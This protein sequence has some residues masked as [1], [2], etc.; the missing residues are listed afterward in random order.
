MERGYQINIERGFD[1]I[2]ESSP[3]A[4]LL[5]HLNALD[6]Q[7]ETL[8]SAQKADTIKIVP[9][10][11]KSAKTIT[12]P[13]IDVLG[14]KQSASPSA[15]ISISLPAQIS[16]S[17]EE[18]SRARQVRD[19]ETKQLESRLGR[20]PQF[21]KA[22]DGLTYTLPIEPRK[23][24]ELPV[25]LQ[26]VRV[27]KLTVPKLYNLEPCSIHLVGAGGGASLVEQAFFDRASQNPL[28][29]LLSQVNFLSQNMHML[30]K[31]TPKNDA[32]SHDEA[33]TTASLSPGPGPILAVGNPDRPHI[34]N[35]PRPLEWEVSSEGGSETSES[36]SEHEDGH[37]VDHDPI[38]AGQGPS[39]DMTGNTPERGILISFPH[40]ELHGIELL[41]LGT[42]NI[43]VKCDR[44]REANDILNLQDNVEGKHTKRASC[45]KCAVPF[46][47]GF[48]AELMHNNSI[49][50]GYLDLEGCYVADMLPSSFIPTCAECSTSYARP[51]VVSVRAETA[52]AFCRQCHQKMTFVL[53]EIKFLRTSTS[54]GHAKAPLR[55]KQTEKLGI[56]AGQEL[57]NRG[58]CAHYKKSYRWFRFSCC[59]KVF[60]CDRCHDEASEHATEHAN[61]MIC[62]FC[63]HPWFHYTSQLSIALTSEICGQALENRIIDR[64]IAASAMHISQ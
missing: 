22:S 6:R 31:H 48:R 5:A 49:R 29:T 56:V 45:K 24:S 46:L 62:G 16:H 44:C 42:L 43:T 34:V 8:L 1:R 9:H 19:V 3:S 12:T 36:C 35:I 4:T 57:T 32:T 50:A 41:E 47:L 61:R 27:V 55:K 20:L 14:D 59:D 7:L 64:K 11:K 60:P 30:A 13:S 58:R 25:D 39:T 10:I 52:M 15:G 37:D 18:T 28:H 38:G 23:R 17:A 53:P 26:G 33:P 51:G 54:L 63:R 40:L 2:V 21:T